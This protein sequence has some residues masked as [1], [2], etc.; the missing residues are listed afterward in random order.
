MMAVVRAHRISVLV[1]R[2]KKNEFFKNN[3]QPPGVTLPSQFSHQF[4]SERM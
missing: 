1:V 4:T 3:E 2:S